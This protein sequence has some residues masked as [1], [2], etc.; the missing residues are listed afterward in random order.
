MEGLMEIGPRP[1]FVPPECP[2]YNFE[3]DSIKDIRDFHFELS[4]HHEEIGEPDTPVEGI[5]DMTFVS[6]SFLEQKG[7]ASSGDVLFT[8]M[9]VVDRGSIAEQEIKEIA[10]DG[11]LTEQLRLA[12]LRRIAQCH[13]VIT[14]EGDPTCWAL[15]EQG[16]LEAIDEVKNQE[17]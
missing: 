8:G 12:L 2:A 1:L 10:E 3:T 17:E 5:D 11:Y 15:S 9:T 13:G 7:I 16:L 14:N 4:V 6:G